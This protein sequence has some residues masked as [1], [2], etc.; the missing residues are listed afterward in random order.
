MRTKRLLAPS[1]RV[2]QRFGGELGQD[3]VDGHAGGKLEARSR[4][5][6]RQELDVPD[7]IR[8]V[9]VTTRRAVDHQVVGR[10]VESDAKS[11]EHIE[12]QFGQERDARG[13]RA[14]EG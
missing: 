13:V 8:L 14:L 9:R 5:G 11:S 2:T 12:Q 10:V 7:E 4:G 3:G 6:A 1:A